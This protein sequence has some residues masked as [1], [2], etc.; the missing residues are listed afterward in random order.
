M[1]LYSFPASTIIRQKPSERSIF[2][3]EYLPVALGVEA[4]LEDG[5]HGSAQRFD[6]ILVG[7]VGCGFVDGRV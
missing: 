3:P 7:D 2:L 5:G 1:K 6:W 4:K